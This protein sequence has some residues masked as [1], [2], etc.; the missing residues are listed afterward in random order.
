[1]LN[2]RAGGFAARSRLPGG[3]HAPPSAAGQVDGK[4]ST[5]IPRPGRHQAQLVNVV[6]VRW[7]DVAEAV[8]FA[9]RRGLAV[10]AR[11]GGRCLPDS[12]PR[13]AW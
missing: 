10:V 12:L 6:A 9:R 13:V 5:G 1:M 7:I 3:L 8:A 4:V 11:S 2:C